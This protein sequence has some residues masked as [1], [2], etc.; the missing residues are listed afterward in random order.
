MPKDLRYLAF[1]LGAESGRAVVGRFDGDTLQLD[2]LH[3][4]PNGP[5]T[6][7]GR[8]YWDVLRLWAEMV[9]GLILYRR[10]YGADLDGIGLDTWGVDFG[11]L[12]ESGELL[13]NPVAYRDHRT[14]GILQHPAVVGQRTRDE[15]RDDLGVGFR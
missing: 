5:V 13:Q 10:E 12:G 14:D 2:T 9:Q 11:I 7:T 8:L 4:F 15:V 1:D 3:R 6:V